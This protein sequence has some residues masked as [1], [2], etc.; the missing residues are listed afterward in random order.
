MKDIHISI[1][2]ETIAHIGNFNITNSLLT[3]L[4]VMLIL[5]IL[6]LRVKRLG[7]INKNSGLYLVVELIIEKFYG[8]IGNIAGKRVDTIF[9][10]I[11]TFFLFIILSN[12]FGL[13]PGI[14]SIGVWEMTDHGKEFIPLFRG[15]T[16]DLNTTFALALISV[17]M[18]QYLGAKTLGIGT[19]AGKFIN[20]RNPIKFF[21]GILELISEFAKT[22]SFSFRLF[23]NI[24]AGEVL[25]VVIVFLVPLLLPIPF[26]MLEIFIG[27]IQALVFMMLTTIF[28]V[29]ATDSSH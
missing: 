17:G 6:A 3:G 11:M 10:L 25:L 15:P 26:L 27:F 28:I 13:L 1:S 29:I 24:F 20:F 23:G 4:I 19:Y 21:V 5:I 12:W 7:R 8:F 2:A 22:L 14:G 18:T 16:A 9:P